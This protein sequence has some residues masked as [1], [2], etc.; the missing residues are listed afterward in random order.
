MSR[1]W[2]LFAESG[3]FVCAIVA[4]IVRLR[5]GCHHLQDKMSRTLKVYVIRS[6]Q[7]GTTLLPGYT[8]PQHINS[9]V[10][11]LFVL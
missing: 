4:V 2:M 9:V 3:N 11:V 1:I 6:S 5:S 8:V 10:G 7:Y